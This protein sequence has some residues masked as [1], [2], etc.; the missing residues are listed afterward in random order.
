ML[1]LNSSRCCWPSLLP[2][3]TAGSC[4]ASYLLR[5]GPFQQR[6]PLAGQSLHCSTAE[7]Y[8][9]PSARLHMDLFLWPFWMADLTSNVSMGPF[10][11]GVI[12]KFD[13]SALYK[14]DCLVALLCYYHCVLF[15]SQKPW[16]IQSQK[17]PYHISLSRCDMCT[18]RRLTKLCRLEETSRR[19]VA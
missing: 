5:P 16:R 9:F 13:G 17:L 10:W 6:C 14:L 19:H 11:F 7:S 18:S 15:G 3:Y 2:D 8:S 4:S 12:R 1:L